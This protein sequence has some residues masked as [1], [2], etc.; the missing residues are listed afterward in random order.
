MSQLEVLLEQMQRQID[1]LDKRIESLEA[2]EYNRMNLMYLTD[3]IT[4]P[5]TASGW[6]ILYVDTADGDL[7]V[8]FGDGHVETIAVDS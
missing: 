1:Q 2:S 6:A 4:A 8:K 3:G 7:K 5:S